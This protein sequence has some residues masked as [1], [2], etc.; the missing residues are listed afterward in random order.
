MPSVAVVGAS[1]EKLSVGQAVLN[2]LVEGTYEGSVYPVNPK[3]K[4]LG[5]VPCYARLSEIGR[6]VDLAVICTPPH[7]VPKIIEDC[8]QAGI[9]AAIILSAGF[10][11]IG[12]NGLLLEE[13][14]KQIAKSFPGMRIVGP[15]CLRMLFPLI[16]DLM[17]VFQ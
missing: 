4:R 14:I 8:G 17:P 15:N 6:P 11:E 7:S 1:H 3:Y 5:S 16:M 2:H 12:T 13:E 9:A 10:R